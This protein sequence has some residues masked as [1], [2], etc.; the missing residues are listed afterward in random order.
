MKVPNWVVL[1]TSWLLLSRRLKGRV[2]QRVGKCR[3]RFGR[4]AGAGGG[5][6]E[7]CSMVLSSDRPAVGWGQELVEMLTQAGQEQCEPHAA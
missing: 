5:V 1:S 2:L 6:S 3:K 7:P 4:T